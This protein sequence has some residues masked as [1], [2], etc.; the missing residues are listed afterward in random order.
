MGK[1]W[2]DPFVPR[3]RMLKKIIANIYV[4]IFLCNVIIFQ[5]ILSQEL[6]KLRSEGEELK[7]EKVIRF[8]MITW[9]ADLVLF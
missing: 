2:I 8:F 5:T 9:L 1:K 6:D 4:I 7:R 3:S